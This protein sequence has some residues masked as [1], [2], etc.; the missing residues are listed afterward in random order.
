MSPDVVTY[1]LISEPLG[2]TVTIVTIVTVM[3]EG[4]LNLN[5]IRLNVLCNQS[6]PGT[7]LVSETWSTSHVE[8]RG[9]NL[10]WNLLENKYLL[11]PQERLRVNT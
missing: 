8:H 6:L 4:L 2:S 3:L 11:C 7:C 5:G 9:F 10:F 1:L